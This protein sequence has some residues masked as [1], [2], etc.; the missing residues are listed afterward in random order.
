MWLFLSIYF[1]SYYRQTE[2]TYRLKTLILDL[3]SAAS[4]LSSSPLSPNPN[5][6]T[7]VLGPEITAAAER[8]LQQVQPKTNSTT[9][10]LGYTFPTQEEVQQFSLP[11][12]Q[13]GGGIG[14]TPGID[15]EQW[16][17]DKV[18]DQD[19]WAVVLVRG[20]ATLLALEALAGRGGEYDREP[21]CRNCHQVFG[22]VK[23]ISTNPF[24]DGKRGYHLHRGSQ[25][26]HVESIRLYAGHR[27]RHGGVQHGWLAAHRE[28]CPGQRRRSNHG[29]R[30]DGPDP[31]V[32]VQRVQLGAV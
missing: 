19:V 26:F 12:R 20:N 3:D 9:W 10:A 16:A 2:N 23:L 4:T 13:Q 30:E 11:Y 17:K 6:Y 32:C 31:A 21:R 22:I 1:G 8:Y 15:A 29:S 28:L 5:P 7:A 24:S 27:A 14:Y 18:H 25:L